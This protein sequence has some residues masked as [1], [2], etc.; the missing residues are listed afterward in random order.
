MSER[1]DVIVI[2]AGPGGEVVAG[3]LHNEHGVLV[4]D[5]DTGRIAAWRRVLDVTGHYSRPDVFTLGV[6]RGARDPV[7]FRPS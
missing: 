6:D 1:F 3:P 7:S 4:A 5:I 2:G